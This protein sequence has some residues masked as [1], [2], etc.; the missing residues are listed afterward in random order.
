MK[1]EKDY[2]KRLKRVGGGIT[3]GCAGDCSHVLTACI[4][5]TSLKGAQGVLWRVAMSLRAGC[6]FFHTHTQNLGV[7]V[8]LGA[9]L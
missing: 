4:Q 8:I 6:F 2:S 1:T 9:I 5:T 7:T 3:Q